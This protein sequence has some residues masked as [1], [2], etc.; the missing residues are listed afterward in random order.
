L[1]FASREEHQGF[2]GQAE[3]DGGSALGDGGEA[4]NSRINFG[5]GSF[6]A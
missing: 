1:Y 4:S 3:G 5:I 2:E 6:F